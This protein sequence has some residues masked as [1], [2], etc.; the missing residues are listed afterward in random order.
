M[1]ETVI[2]YDLYCWYIDFGAPGSCNDINVLDR[3]NTILG[4]LRGENPLEVTNSYKINGNSRNW[5]Y[6][7]VD[8]M[9]PSWA[10]FIEP[11]PHGRQVV[12]P[13]KES[14]FNTN[15]EAGRKDVERFYSVL[16]E[17]FQAL[18][19]AIRFWYLSDI[20]TIVKCCIILHN[21]VVEDK[22]KERERDGIRPAWYRGETSRFA[23]AAMHPMEVITLFDLDAEPCAE[24]ERANNDLW[25][26]RVARISQGITNRARHLDLKHDLIED[27]WNKHL[28]NMT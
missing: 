17:R 15:Q 22:K 10:I 20:E 13:D 24:Q 12:L 11:I 28:N 5:A 3:S 26:V 14:Y 7:L 6:F 27:M 16:E 18:K 25:A 19:Q 4:M 9:Y 23:D 8:S 1:A 2:D 21:M